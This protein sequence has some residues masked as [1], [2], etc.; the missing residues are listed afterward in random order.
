MFFYSLDKVLWF[1]IITTPLSLNVKIKE[2]GLAVS[3]PGEPLMIGVLILFIFKIIYDSRIERGIL[4]HP[5]T[6]AILT[7]L[8]WVLITTITSTL[9][10][11]SFK[12]LLARLWFIVC[13]YYFTIILFKNIKN[14]QRF[15]WAYILPLTIVIFYTIIVHSQYGFTVSSANWVMSPFYNDHTIY[16]AVL[17]MYFPILIYFVYNK[18]YTFPKKAISFVFLIIFVIALVLSYTRAAWISLLAAAIVGL[19]MFFRISVQTITFSGLILLGLFFVSKDRILMSLE[20][21]RQDSSSKLSEHVQSISNISSD[22]SNLERLNRWSA[23]IRMY[24]KHP[25][26]GFGPGTYAFKY[27]PYQFSYEKTIISTN[28]GNRGNAHSEYIGP[29]AESGGLGLITFSF[30]VIAIFYSGITLYLKMEKGQLRALLMAVILGLVTYFVH[31]FL[32]NFLDTDKAAVPVWGFA[33]I[34][35]AIQLY[36]QNLEKQKQE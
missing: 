6:I 35:V 21:N 1:I 9:P 11:I 5:I 10:V 22:A 3:L 28:A 14:I 26:V 30:I 20:K 7:Y 24:E 19:I 13:F 15:L 18:E 2:F 8:G 12:F 27:A 23:A 25:W 36:H 33:A 31:G 34:I 32:N 29:L 16:G 4:K 17:A